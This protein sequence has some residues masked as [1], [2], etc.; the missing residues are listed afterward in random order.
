MQFLD[1]NKRNFLDRA[2]GGLLVGAPRQ[3][4]PAWQQDP[5]LVKQLEA[6]ERYSA[7][8]AE[9]Q[10]AGATIYF[11]DEAGIRFDYHTGTTWALIGETPVVTVTGRRFS[12]NMISAGSPRGEIRRRK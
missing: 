10:A 8:K 11:A 4:N 3:A 1:L 5:V 2:R 12:F 6:A 7:I 9:A